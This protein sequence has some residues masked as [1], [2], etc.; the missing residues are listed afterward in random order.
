MPLGK[1]FSQ[2]NQS[3]KAVL[4]SNVSMQTFLDSIKDACM[5]KCHLSTKATWWTS[6]LI[7]FT[8]IARSAS[9]L[10]IIR[11]LS[12]LV[13]KFEFL[14]VRNEENVAY[15]IVLPERILQNTNSK[16][17]GLFPLVYIVFM[18]R[19]ALAKKSFR[20]KDTM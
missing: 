18:H 16:T 4:K 15:C 19:Q 7:A 10:E 8:S 3:D 11:K 9:F 6:R 12:Y 20:S 2:I 17:L 14:E 13:A 1:P 5:N